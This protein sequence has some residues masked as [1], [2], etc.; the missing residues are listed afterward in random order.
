MR[1]VVGA[2]SLLLLVLLAA[3]SCGGSVELAPFGSG[4]VRSEGDGGVFPTPAAV[5]ATLEK[6]P[7]GRGQELVIYFSSRSLSCA[8]LQPGALRGWP[9]ANDE[10][11]R[12]FLYNL[13][14]D[15]PPGTYELG[16]FV[17]ADYQTT[18][19]T[20]DLAV[21]EATRL[22]LTITA[23]GGA[24]VA[25]HY[26]VTFA[27]Q[28]MPPGPQGTFTGNFF[29]PICELTEAAADAGPAPA[30]CAQ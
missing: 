20:C 28:Y 19:A 2:V 25:G 17:A 24:S 8:E 23:I 3:S 5:V 13:S 9:P 16:A 22:T 12:L 21:S 6:R 7:S 30:V 14:G 10:V 11:I 15:I 29:L 27:A 4:S 18:T 26:S 1:N